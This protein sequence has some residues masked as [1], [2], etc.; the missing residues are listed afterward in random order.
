M[1]CRAIIA[2]E[3]SR[4]GALEALERVRRTI[5][6]HGTIVAEMPADESPIDSSL[7]ANLLVSVG[8]DGTF[9]AQARRAHAA[10]LPLVGVHAGRLGFLTSFTLDDLARHAPM[11]FGGAPAVQRRSVHSVTIRQNGRESNG[12][13]VNDCVVTAGHPF[14]MLQ[15]RL[16]IDG[17]PGPVF[18]GDGLIFATSLGSTAYN[19][20]AGGPIVHPSADVLLVTPIAPHSLSFRPIVL[21]GNAHVQVRVERANPG[22]TVI[23]DGQP[24]TG[25]DDSDEVVV[26]GHGSGVRIVANPDWQHWQTLQRKMR[27]A[28]APAYAQDK[29][30]PP[31]Q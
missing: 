19:L 27:W 14:T 24:V 17:E 3:T 29:E 20:S 30:T 10:D 28:E 31:A 23:V 9:L 15:L 4:P 7:G 13:C 12:I 25:V 21:P 26:R 2:C 6:A 11:V 22:T 8:G 1:S 16:T 18:R 5:A